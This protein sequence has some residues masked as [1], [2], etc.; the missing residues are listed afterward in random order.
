[1]KFISSLKTLVIFL[2]GI[3]MLYGC[4]SKPIS[5]VTAPPA[6]L[7]KR[8]ELDPMYKKL[9]S[10]G[11][12][13]V[14]STNSVNDYALKE[15]V[16]LINVMLEGR[17][18]LRRMLIKKKVRYIVYGIDEF[19]TDFPEHKHLAKTKK[20]KDWWDRRARGLGAQ[21]HCPATSCGEENLL[22]YKG[23]PYHSENILIHE[24]AHTIHQCAIDFV[25]KT[26]DKRL[27]AIYKKAM[28]KGLWKGKYAARNRMEYW[29]EG[30]QSWFNN[31]RQP[32]HDHNHVDTRKELKEY[33][34]D[35]AAIIEEIFGT[36]EWTYTKPTTRMHLDHLQGYD[37]AKAPEFSWP[38]RLTKQK[39]R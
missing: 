17:E 4:Q 6:E 18:D 33:D 28:D 21:P 39:I 16:Y 8:L 15:A 3:T 34:P 14:V 13:P 10:A 23:D 37:P 9:C 27:Q 35:L 31:N 7:V 1:M 38:K 32:D 24:F 19:T 20:G 25:D 36:R 30:V 22:S 12:F 29:A 5:P 2:V 26:F 11:G